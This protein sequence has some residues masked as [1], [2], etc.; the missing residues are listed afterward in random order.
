MPVRPRLAR[1]LAWRTQQFQRWLRQKSC[2]R[3]KSALYMTCS[4][5]APNRFRVMRGA[6]ICGSVLVWV[7]ML[8]ECLVPNVAARTESVTDEIA[9]V[10]RR[11]R[12]VCIVAG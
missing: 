12:Y 11:L 8:R 4:L 6:Q 9:A 7:P 2:H 3:S 10:A 1:L 5:F